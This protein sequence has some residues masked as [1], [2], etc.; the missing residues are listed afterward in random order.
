MCR[1]CKLVIEGVEFSATLIF[2]PLGD[3]DVILGMDWLGEY[4]DKI[5]CFT[6]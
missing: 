4:P 6:K 2:M 5:D 3:F 1:G